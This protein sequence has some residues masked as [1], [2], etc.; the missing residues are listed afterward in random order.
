MSLEG[1]VPL[2]SPCHIGP[3]SRIHPHPTRTTGFR[4]RLLP[5]LFLLVLAS[6][7]VENP[8]MKQALRQAV[9]QGRQ[10]LTGRGDG[11]ATHQTG[12]TSRQAKGG[13]AQARTLDSL[14]RLATQDV[15]VNPDEGS[16]QR[17]IWRVRLIKLNLSTA[18]RS[19]DNS[20]Q[21][22]FN[23]AATSE[24]KKALA[25]VE[26][27]LAA[28]PDSLQGELVL[29]RQRLQEEAIEK[30]KADG[31]LQEKRLSGQQAARAG[32]LLYNLGV[33]VVCDNL[34]LQHSQS[35]LDDFAQVR[36]ELFNEGGL[37]GAL[38]WL[39][40]AAW[41]KE[42]LAIPGDLKHILGEAPAQISALGAMMGTIRV[43][44]QN[45]AIP[46]REVKPGDSFESLEEF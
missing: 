6:S 12:T 15:G 44:K 21:E 46:E 39:D 2:G 23:L 43:L 7:C 13:G 5:V 22:I 36:D 19:L 42:F 32:L 45:N 38:A 41:H 20:R 8:V 4:F 26:E 24:E 33:G 17:A 14:L 37:T 29:E 10:Q 34:A 40:L 30:A 9:A 18:R 1:I 31:R 16:V 27:G 11:R 28:M 3:M 35:V 25:Q